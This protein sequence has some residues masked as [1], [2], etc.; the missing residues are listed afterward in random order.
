MTYCDSRSLY[1]LPID[2]KLAMSPL[3]PA[4]F[5]M[6]AMIILPSGGWMSKWNSLRT[7]HEVKLPKWTS[8]NVTVSGKEIVQR[9]APAEMTPIIRM[10]NESTT[11][12]PRASWNI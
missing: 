6:E 11:V 12:K 8:S 2:E 1:S 5:A 4:I 9:R 3:Y 10:M 7:Y